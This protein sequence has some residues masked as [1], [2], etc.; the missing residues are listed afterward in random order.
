MIQPFWLLPAGHRKAECP[1]GDGLYDYRF[2]F[3]AHRVL[4]CVPDRAPGDLSYRRG[5]FVLIRFLVRRTECGTSSGPSLRAVVTAFGQQRREPAK[6]STSNSTASTGG[7][8]RNRT[9]SRT[10]DLPS[11]PF[12]LDR[13]DRNRQKNPGSGDDW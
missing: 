8:V 6:E 9:S 3:R 10:P 2:L 1:P 12:R 5:G 7:C 13:C 11:R 4:R